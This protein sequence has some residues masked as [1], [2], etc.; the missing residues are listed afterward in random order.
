MQQIMLSAF[1]LAF[2]VWV[3]LVPLIK[4]KEK[5]V[6]WFA[7]PSY[8]IYLILNILVGLNVKTAGLNQIIAQLVK[9]AMKLE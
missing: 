8:L 3:D 2:C 6:L 5:K 1:L 9:S 4:K 7:I